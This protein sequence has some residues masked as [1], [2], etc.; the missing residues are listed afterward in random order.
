MASVGHEQDSDDTVTIICTDDKADEFD[1][2]ELSISS[3][4]SW[5]VPSIL[6]HTL[7][8][9]KVNSNKLIEE[10]SYF[11]GL[12]SGSFSES[13]LDSIPIHWNLESFVSVLMVIFGC[14]VEISSDNFIPL[15][16]M[17]ASSFNSF[18]D[19]P[20]E[21]LCSCIK[22]PD[23]TV[24]SER[25]LCNATL[26][27]LTAKTTKSEGWIDN[28]DHEKIRTTLLPLW[29]AAGTRRC[30]LFSKVA[31]RAT[32]AILSLAKQPSLSLIGIFREGDMN[33]NRIRLTKYT[34]SF[35]KYFAH[36]ILQKVD[37]SGCPQITLGL[38]LLSVLPSC[39]A[40]SMLRKIIKK[41]SINH[42]II[43]VDS[44]Q[45]SLALGQILT[46]EAVQEVDISNC[47][48]L[49]LDSIVDC[50]CKSFPSLRTLRAAYF[51][52]FRTTKL[53]WLVQKFPLLTNV[54]L[55]LDI[56]PLIPSKVSVISSSPIPKAQRS[57][58]PVDI[59]SC[60]SVASLSYTLKPLPSYITKLTLEGRTDISEV[61]TSLN[62]VNLKGCISVTDRG[63]SAMILKC[64]NLQSVLA[65]DTSFGNSSILALCS[66][67]SSAT[68]G[69]K[70]N[71][72]LNVYK[73]LDLHIS[74]C[75]GIDGVILSELLSGADY[76]RS[77][78][79]RE[80]QFIDNALCSFS[81]SSLK[82]LDVSDTKVSCAALYH[83]ICRNP[84]LK[85]LKTRGCTN[86]LQLEMESEERKL[87]NA[88][89][90]KE[91]L[92]SQ[93][94]KS[95]K[96]E[97]I[98]FGWGFSLLSLE[99]LK[100]AIRTL[101][102]IQIGVGGSL[103]HNG[104]KLLPVLCPLLETLILYFQVISDSVIANITKTLPHLQFLALCYCLGDISSL[105]F[106]SRLPNLRNLKLERVAPWMTNGDLA[107][108]AGN[109][110]NL[111]ELSLIGCTLL[112]S[113]SQD[114]ISSGW[115]GLTC[116]RLEECGEITANGVGSLSDCHA[117]EDLILR[118]TVSDVFAFL[119]Q[120]SKSMGESL[121]FYSCD[122]YSIP[123]EGSG[124]PRN[125]II[126]AAS[127]VSLATNCQCFGKY[128]LTYVMQGRVILTFQVYVGKYSLHIFADR[129]F[130]SIVK[131]A[132][133]KL[134]KCTLDFGDVEARR[135]PVHKETL[136]LY[137]NSEKLVR[138]VVKERL[139]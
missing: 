69:S 68:Q 119:L 73:L 49:S 110:A 33:H 122:L 113:E 62:Y 102:T 34:Q 71:S 129:Y 39:G 117:L 2:I 97:E 41:S 51:L 105:G 133:C 42:A 32:A 109:C 14:P 47:P 77:L 94:G 106:S 35:V 70:K 37:L 43:G 124:I 61:C 126:Y 88:S 123:I 53:C 90:T 66:G 58:T 76:L 38:F 28:I 4:S 48:S 80:I 3:I 114:I 87:C 11:R 59:H 138:T 18:N 127:K 96:L 21:L 93:L 22:H 27:W 57:T 82:I 26:V 101:R 92:Y 130:L 139:Y 98:E 16:E 78:C 74:G 31:G 17:W 135:T 111:V 108:L 45:I 30:R 131:I 107:T 25:H 1:E 83:V 75:Y 120:A 5:D 72:Q 50:L 19:L 95:C 8:K 56:N 23:L 89:F 9:I 46:F 85:C 63:I 36:A 100:P 103:G 112:N 29:F 52:N 55:T 40:D 44:S 136:V 132:R 116:L 10:S 12:L 104:L 121:I 24:D 137:W 15:Y 64:K 54:D 99:A 20:G 125:F 13:G 60:H 81:G 128:H 91:E 7:L 134:Q 118:H 115:P 67:N 84:D 79:L 6:S 65:C 86:L